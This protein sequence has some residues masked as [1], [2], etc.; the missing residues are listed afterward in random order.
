M[1]PHRPWPR[2]QPC[3]TTLGDDRE[4]AY[5]C[6]GCSAGAAVASPAGRR[7]VKRA[8]PPGA[9]AAATRPPW[10]STIAGDDG[11][12]EPGA[13]AA[14]LA[15]RLGAP[16]AVEQRVAVV[17]R[18]AGA[19]VAHLEAD[20]ARRSRATGTSIGVPGGRVHERVAHQVRRAPGGAG[21]GRRDDGGRVG[22]R[23][24]SMSRSGRASRA[25]RRPRRGR[26]R[27]GRR[28][29][30][31]G[32]A[33]L[34]EAGE[35]QQVLDEDAHAR[36]LVLDAAHRLRVSASRVARRADAEQLG[37]AADRGQRRAQLVRG[38]GQEAAQ[39]VLAGLAL[40]ERALEAVEHRVEGQAEAPDLRARVGGLSRGA[41]GRR[42]RSR[43]AVAPD[44]V[45][46]AQAEPH[47]EPGDEAA[48]ASS[49][50]RDDEA[51]DEQQAVQR[52]VDLVQRHGDDRDRAAGRRRRGEHA[53]A[54]ARRR[55]SAVTVMTWSAAG[56]PAAS[57]AAAPSGP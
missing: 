30:A 1:C 26:C 25:R 5:A 52:L 39:A 8:P 14:A 6:A 20:L 7:T 49:T 36:R 13:G 9:L 18:Q 16:E 22:A 44:A 40:G 24:A 2:W 42:R 32:V 33:D 50:P 23:R 35:R 43:P 27:P 53:V 10:A 4:P 11:E 45:Q 3:E 17:G 37:V 19:V 47:D 28:G 21:G 55:P 31:D 15:A 48:S 29:C 34:V 56:R 41:R 38:V 46:R 12:P 57:G 51:L 54:R